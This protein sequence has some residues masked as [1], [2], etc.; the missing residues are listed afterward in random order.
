MNSLVTLV[1]TAALLV[2][3]VQLGSQESRTSTSTSS[4]ARI[5]AVPAKPR[6]P[7]DISAAPTVQASAACCLKQCADGGQCGQKCDV[8]DNMSGCSSNFAFECGGKKGLT[9]IS[10]TCTCE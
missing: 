5:T 9:C 1:I 7:G 2:Y 10:G 3:S 8:V 4:P 6:T